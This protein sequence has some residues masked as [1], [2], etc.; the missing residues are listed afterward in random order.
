MVTKKPLEITVDWKKAMGY[1]L[2]GRIPHRQ[3]E[4]ENILYQL[5]FLHRTHAGQQSDLLFMQLGFTVEIFD[6]TQRGILTMRQYN[7]V[8]GRSQVG[9]E[10]TGA[11]DVFI[12]TLLRF[13]YSLFI[14]TFAQKTNNERSQESV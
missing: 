7:G 3:G 13:G 8:D 9:R 12:E 14:S 6:G 2:R 1:S 10:G 5:C 11:L 4:I